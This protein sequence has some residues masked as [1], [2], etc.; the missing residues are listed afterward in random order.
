VD[1]LPGAAVMATMALL[2]YTTPSAAVGVH[3]TAVVAGVATAV[4]GGRRRR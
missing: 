3:G 4:S 2:A 1:L